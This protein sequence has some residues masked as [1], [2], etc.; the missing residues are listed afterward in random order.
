MIAIDALST[1]E[2]DRIV[3][4]QLEGDI[5][6]AA[7]RTTNGEATGMVIGTVTQIHER[8]LDWTERGSPNP[9]LPFTTHL[10]HPGVVFSIH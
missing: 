5:N 3:V 1:G 6:A 4:E 2:R 7:D 10:A 8:V 9:M